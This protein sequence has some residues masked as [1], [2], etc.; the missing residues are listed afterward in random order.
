MANVEN[1][2]GTFQ[3]MRHF[4]AD[5]VCVKGDIFGYEYEWNT[6]CAIFFYVSGRKKATR[7]IEVSCTHEIRVLQPN[8]FV[9]FEVTVKFKHALNGIKTELNQ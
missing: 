3:F 8:I 4:Y 9:P 6:F 1:Y 5:I 2:A 7:L